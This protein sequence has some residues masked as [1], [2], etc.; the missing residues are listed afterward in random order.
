MGSLC[1][2]NRIF[3]VYEIELL[4]ECTLSTEVMRLKITP[5]KSANNATKRRHIITK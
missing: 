4:A 3:K 5:A 2:Y 1:I